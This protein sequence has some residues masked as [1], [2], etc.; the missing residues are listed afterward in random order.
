[1]SHTDPIISLN[2]ITKQ[3]GDIVALKDI[4]ADILRG[5]VLAIIGPNGSGKSTLAKIILGLETPTQ[6]S[7]TIHAK[8]NVQSIGYVPQRLDFDRSIPITVQE[9]LQLQSCATPGHRHTSNI[10]AALDRVGLTGQEQKI[11]GQLSGGQFQRLVL[12]RALMHKKEILILDEPESH[13]DAAGEQMIYDM[14]REL[15]NEGMTIIII[16]HDVEAVTRLADRVLCIN[17]S[18][19]CHG[20]THDKLTQQAI[21]HISHR[22]AHL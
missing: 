7:V 2:N 4:T 16:S 19:V 3:F 1:M 11:L 5:D 8:K 9:F 15:S 14:L 17:C 20:S 22:H 6:G 13:I 12:A 18:V 10:A 21:E